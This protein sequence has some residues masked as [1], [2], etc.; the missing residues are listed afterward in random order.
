MLCLLLFELLLLLLRMRMALLRLLLGPLADLG[1]GLGLL[2]Q[3]LLLLELL[4]ELPLSLVLELLLVVR[5]HD[6]HPLA[7]LRQGHLLEQALA[8]SLRRVKHLEA[9]HWHLL[10]RPD[11]ADEVLLPLHLVLILAL[12]PLELR[13]LLLPELLR[14]LGLGD[15]D[16]LHD[17]LGIR[18]L[19][20]RLLN[21][22]LLLLKV[23]CSLLLF[24]LQFRSQ[25]LLVVV[26]QNLL[27]A[28]V[29]L[30]GLDGPFA[31]ELH[32]DDA[33]LHAL[34]FF[35]MILLLHIVLP[36]VEL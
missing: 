27:L 24:R 35:E 26:C 21:E 6:L 19:R 5:L 18:P 25:D 7:Q 29:G 36:S 28:L 34:F 12:L 1:Q 20:D 32:L 3:L 22:L 31:G 4:F 17:D 8:R 30:R 15:N 23:H 33:L 13:L 2:C 11:L 16:L 9:A 10:Q 14:I